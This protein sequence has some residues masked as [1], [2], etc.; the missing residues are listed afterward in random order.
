MSKLSQAA[1]EDAGEEYYDDEL[2]REEQASDKAR[3]IPRISRQWIP[4][5]KGRCAR[6]SIV[7][8]TARAIKC[9][10]C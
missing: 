9:C 10:P 5:W 8:A 3:P 2:P 6:A 7:A 4:W 1:A